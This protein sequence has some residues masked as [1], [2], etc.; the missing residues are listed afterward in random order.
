VKN[1]SHRTCRPVVRAVEALAVEA[2]RKDGEATVRLQAHDAAVAVLVDREP[3]LPVHGQPVG[4][5]LP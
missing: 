1:S 5:G 3:A 2:R 4:P